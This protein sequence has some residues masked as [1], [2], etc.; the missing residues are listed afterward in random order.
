MRKKKEN[1]VINNNFNK[2]YSKLNTTPRTSSS[3]S[4]NKWMYGWMDSW[5]ADGLIVYENG[6]PFG[7]TVYICN[8]S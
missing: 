2:F 7:C 1:F 4:W 6:T 8:T 3:R 5:L